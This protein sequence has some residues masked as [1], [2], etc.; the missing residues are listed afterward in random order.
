MSNFQARLTE[1]GLIK[2]EKDS[3]WRKRGFQE[4]RYIVSMY[5]YYKLN[6]FNS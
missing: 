3:N 5:N 4:P 2:A 1:L 6:L